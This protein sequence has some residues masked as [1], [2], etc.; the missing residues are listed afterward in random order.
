M[1]LEVLF[2]KGA[3]QV[4]QVPW[5]VSNEAGEVISDGWDCE[6]ALR[7]AAAVI[8]AECKKESQ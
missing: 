5:F 6:G 8:E 1:K 2:D 4:G 3:E 7:S